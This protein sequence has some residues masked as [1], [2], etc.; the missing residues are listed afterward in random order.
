MARIDNLL[1]NY[2]RH[3]A[4]SHRPGLT[5]SER[6][7]FLVYPPE[8]ERRVQVRMLE[9]QQATESADHN[10]IEVDLTNSFSGWMDTFDPEERKACLVDPVL[11]EEYAMPSYRNFVLDEIINKSIDQLTETDPQQSI[12]AIHGLLELY[13]FLQVSSIIEGITESFKGVIVVFFPGEK[14]ANSYRF[15]GAR[16]GW[17]YLAVPILCE[18]QI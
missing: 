7:W 10:W 5:L 12:V 2:K 1:A 9:F 14:E 3:L 6:V 13:D 8:D 11:V 4:V 15:V 16:T 17:N 18:S